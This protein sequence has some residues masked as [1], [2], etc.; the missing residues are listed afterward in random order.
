VPFPEHPFPLATHL[1]LDSAPRL[2]AGGVENE[3][4]GTSA[5]VQRIAFRSSSFVLLFLAYAASLSR[6]I[7]PSNSGSMKSFHDDVLNITYFYPATFVPAPPNSTPPDPSKCIKSTLFAYSV[8]PIESSSFA[9]STIDDTCPETLRTAMEIGPFTRD[10]VLR[11]LKQYGQPK[12]TQ[13]PSRYSIAGHPAAI[14]VASVAIPA[15]PGKVAQVIYAAKACA[16]GNISVK[17]HRRSDP[18]EPVTHVV[19]FDFNTQN[20]GMLAEMFSFIIQF[21]NAQLQPMFPSNVIHATEVST[22]R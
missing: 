22:R 11:Q 1:L 4:N 3:M 10:Q 19:C 2:L 9:L 8:T 6:A 18:A 20:G 21:D 17:S 7:A 12:I 16:F 14:T 13:E 15:V 5:S